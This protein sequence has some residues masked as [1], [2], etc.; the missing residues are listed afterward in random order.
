MIKRIF[1]S[2]S[3]KEPE[4][5]EFLKLLL[6]E[7]RKDFEVN[8]DSDLLKKPG[9]DW[10]QEIFTWM[11][12]CDGVIILLDKSTFEKSIWVP[13]ESIIMLW[14]LAHDPDFI[15]IPVY[16]GVECKE[17]EEQKLFKELNLKA[18]MGIFQV[19]GNCRRT[20]EEMIKDIKSYLDEKLKLEI[21]S[22]PLEKL[23]EQI[24]KWLTSISEKDMKN[25]CSDFK[26]DSGPWKPMEKPHQAIA[27]WML[28]VGLLKSTEAL[29]ELKLD[30]AEKK[31]IFDLLTP[32]WVDIYS[33]GII[34]HIAMNKKYK[35]AIVLN[36][37]SEFS[38]KMYIQRASCKLPD[39]WPIYIF[40]DK[41]GPS[42]DE[43]ANEIEEWLMRDF[44]PDDLDGLF[45]DNR[46]R[47][48]AL[49][50]I[51]ADEKRL[52]IF[53]VFNYSKFEKFLPEL[54]KNDILSQVTFFLLTGETYPEQEKFEELQFSLIEP[55]LQPNA[56]RQAY[57]EYKKA[58]NRIFIK[59]NKIKE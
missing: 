4:T 51:L 22:K 52:P 40:P 24:A 41:N 53:I 2:H 30:V 34:P 58:F 28:K 47:R 48:E 45:V 10:R 12:R 39:S 35:S 9:C 8:V 38:A 1:I 33:A 3:D 14:R 21:C 7:L 20:P 19:L 49:K 42:K 50:D 26:V 31:N 11:G 43:I 32:S 36:A 54:Q 37:K 18:L 57:I 27:C 5:V 25:L 44:G 56:E 15:I 29:M 17:V 46:E 16:I 23:E 59:K 55:P 6:E 13:F